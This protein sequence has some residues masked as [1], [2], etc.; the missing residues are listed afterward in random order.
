MTEHTATEEAQ[1]GE[2]ATVTM[3]I[4]P[5]EGYSP[6]QIRTP[7]SLGRLRNL[8]A[9]AIEIYG[10]DAAVVTDNH[11]RT[12]ASYGRIDRRPFALYDETEV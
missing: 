3:G 12:G 10:E 2:R 8:V 11:Q 5:N 4:R 6:G 9:E 1:A 7:M